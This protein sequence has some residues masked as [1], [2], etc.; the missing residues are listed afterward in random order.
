MISRRKVVAGGVAVALALVLP[1]PALADEQVLGEKTVG[2]NDRRD[3]IDVGRGEGRFTHLKLAV[4]DNPVFLERVV[5]Y[6]ANGDASELPVRERI[7]RDGETRFMALPGDN[8]R[9]IRRIEIH[10]ERTAQGDR[11]RIIAIG[12]RDD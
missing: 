7:R 11:A 3:V 6:Y 5:V 9:I 2:F 10:Y 8:A 1:L 12:R 4:R